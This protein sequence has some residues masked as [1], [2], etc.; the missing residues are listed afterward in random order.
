MKFII[1]FL[2]FNFINICYSQN[3][4][5][6][7]QF[8]GRY[9]FTFIGNTLNTEEN[10]S[11][12]GE[13]PPPCIILNTSS[14]TLNLQPNDIL[15]KAYLYW[16]GSGTGDFSIKLNNENIVPDRTFSDSTP[17]GLVDFS[18][19]KDITQQVKLTGNGLYTVSDFDISNVITPYCPSGSNFGGWAI[20]LVYKNDNLPFNQI[21]IYDGLQSVPNFINITLNSLNVIDNADA[22]IGFVAWEGDKNLA[23]NETLSF[24]GNILTNALNP[25]NNA[26]NGTSTVTGSDRLFNMD[27]DI[28]DIQNN[29]SIGD[30]SATINL[31]SNQD[32]VMINVI[33]TKLNSKLPDATISLSNIQKTCNSRTILADFTIGNYN[34]TNFLPAGTKVAFYANNILVGSYDTPNDIPIDG[35]ISG[36]ISLIIPI[37]IPSDFELKA[38]VDDNGN[39]TSSVAEIIENNNIFIQNFAFYVVPS[40]NILPNK[41]FCL[42]SL[43]NA[44]FDFSSYLDDVKVINSDTVSFFESSQNAADNFDPILNSSNYLLSQAT[45][46]I[47]VRIQNANCFSITSFTINLVLFPK[48]NFLNDLFVCKQNANSSFNFTAYLTSV[49][50][51]STDAVSFFES[52]NNANSNKDAITNITKFIPNE[53]IKEIFVRIDNGICYSTTSFKVNYLGLPTFNLLPNLEKCNQGLTSGL[54]DFSEYLIKTKT[55]V[56]DV[57]TFHN[58]ESDAISGSNSI[59]NNS[60]FLSETTPKQI[61][62][63]IENTNFCYN[64]TSFLLTTKRCPITIYNAVSPNNDGA[65]DTFFIAGLRDVF[66]DFESEIYNRWG[67]LVYKGNNFNEDFSGYSNNGLYLDNKPLP[68]G[69]YFYVLKLNDKDYPKPYS[70]YLYLNK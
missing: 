69:T 35:N 37:T 44:I 58:S 47:F 23:E 11:I 33:V 38:V 46:T 7:K 27:L 53:T 70:G 20:V 40:F 36:Q 10:N 19:F 62:V 42:L 28:Y 25:P 55:N 67:Q 21:N 1:Y 6:F 9:D 51:N 30:T 34:C 49:K 43:T 8:S 16:A 12:N 57:V 60:N 3:V 68:A 17:T 41:Y 32:F 22:K 2:L 29:I 13:P 14:A 61:F 56:T 15:V 50:T 31:T 52:L 5:L 59:G 65:N 4:A 66:L 48:F 26:F 45:K 24:N 39:G 54:F 63:R 18:A 64:T